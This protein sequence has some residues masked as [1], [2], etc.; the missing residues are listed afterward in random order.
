MY[1]HTGN[2]PPHWGFPRSVKLA[3]LTSIVTPIGIASGGTEWT[4]CSVSRPLARHGSPSGKSREGTISPLADI[5]GSQAQDEVRRRGASFSSCPH[6]PATLGFPWPASWRSTRPRVLCVE[7]DHSAKRPA[8]A[9]VADGTSSGSLRSCMATLA[10]V[11]GCVCTRASWIEP[12]EQG[13]PG[14]K[15]GYLVFAW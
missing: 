1:L 3:I 12:H 13:V 10:T 15:T 5:G 14:S 2:F 11:N 4:R 9:T 7:V 8:R 6:D